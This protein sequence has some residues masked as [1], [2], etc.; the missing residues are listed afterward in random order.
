[1]RCES[2]FFENP[3]S[4]K[5]CNL[6]AAFDCRLVSHPK[7]ALSMDRVPG[8]SLRIVAR[9][10]DSVVPDYARSLLASEVTHR[11]VRPE[12]NQGKTAC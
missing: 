2:D 10:L 4:E 7:S 8:D 5:E 11:Q 9:P 3:E 12:E 1:M 6:E